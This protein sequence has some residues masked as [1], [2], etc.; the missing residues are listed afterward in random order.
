[1]IG[2][3]GVVSDDG[4]EC[5]LKIS[6]VTSH[7]LSARLGLQSYSDRNFRLLGVAGGVST[8]SGFSFMS[9]SA[10]ATLA[11]K[12]FDALRSVLTFAGDCGGVGMFSAFSVRFPRT[13]GVD[14]FC[15][16]RGI[17]TV[18]NE[19]SGRQICRSRCRAAIT[20]QMCL[21]R[22]NE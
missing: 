21:R 19:R 10:N 22:K 16:V 2:V 14:C 15:G 5:V 17:V 3:R 7:N 18:G 6:L 13:V 8:L 4:V 20:C 12:S 1:V 9:F 11:G